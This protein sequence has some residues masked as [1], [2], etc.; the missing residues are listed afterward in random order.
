MG[1]IINGKHIS[2]VRYADDT[3]LLAES[4]NQLQQM[5]NNI[6]NCCKK[7]GMS[8]NAKKTKVM[9]TSKKDTR[10]Q[11][12]ITVNARLEQLKQYTYLGSLIT[13]DG[14]CIQEVKK[15][16][17]Q[18]KGAFWKTGE[19]L[20]GNMNIKLKLRL[21][22]CYVF[23]VLAY[24]VE[25]WTYSIEIKRRIRAFEMWTYRRMLKISWTERVTNETVKQR[26][27]VEEDLVLVL[28]R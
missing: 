18:A 7:L 23:S 25:T 28:A 11:L 10:E 26:V 5:I 6:N 20:R 12:E 13:H 1:V 21:I 8:L 19:L 15:R 3:A 14:R 22:K 4:E 27:N 9:V 24:A 16:I 17:A 2:N